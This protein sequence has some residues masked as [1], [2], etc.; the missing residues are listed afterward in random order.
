MDFSNKI[1]KYKILFFLLIINKR[2]FYKNILYINA[3]LLKIN[4]YFIKELPFLWLLLFIFNCPILKIKFLEEINSILII[5]VFKVF[6]YVKEIFD[7]LNSIL[8]MFT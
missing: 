8:E 1:R 5:Y 2:R 6:S 3:K 4:Y 7:V